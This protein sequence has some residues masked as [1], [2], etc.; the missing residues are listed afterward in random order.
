MTCSTKLDIS[1]AAEEQ[2]S[3]RSSSPLS[4]GYISPPDEGSLSRTSPSTSPSRSSS[5]IAICGFGLRL[6]GGVRDGDSFWDLLVNG[7]DARMP[8]PASR[9]N[10]LGFDAS[11]DSKDAIRTQHGYFLD[12]D[13]ASL[14]AS[15]FSMTKAELEKCDPQQRQLLEVTRECLDDAGE[16]DHRGQNVGCYVGNFGHDWME[17]SLREPQHTRSYN[18]LGYSDMML[19]NRVSYEFDLRGPSVVVKSACSASLVALHEACRALQAGDIAGAVVAGTSLILAPTLTSNFFAEGILSPS[20]SCKTFDAAAD[21][22]ARAEGIAAIYVKRL[23]D[24]IRDGN[25]VRA[26][27]RGTASNS[28]GRSMGIMSPSSE[29]HEALMRQVYAMAGLDPRQTAFVEC[30][31]TGTAAGDPIETRAVGNVFGERGVYITSVKPNVGHSEGCSGLTSLIKGILALEHQTIPPNIKFTTPNPKIPFAEKKLVVPVTPT[32]FPSDRAERVSI[33]SFGIGGSNAHAVIESLSQYLGRARNRPALPAAPATPKPELL[34]F[35]ANSQASLKRQIDAYRAYVPQRPEAVAE[36]AYTLAL[37]REHL[38]HRAFAIVKDAALVEVSG[39]SKAPIAGSSSSSSSS[40]PITMVF[41]G[42][43]AQWPEMGKQ[44]ILTNDRFRK[45]LAAM[46]QILQGFRIPPSWSIIE[47]LQK[48][49]DVSQVNCAELAQ[50]LCTALQ[51]ALYQELARGG[52]RPAAVVGHSSGE[53][54]AAYAAGRISLEYALAAAYYRGYVTRSGGRSGAMAAVGLSAADASRFLRPGVCV[55]C[56]NSPSSTTISGDREAL[57]VVVMTLKAEMPDVFARLLKVEMAYHS[58][59]M[60]PLGLDYLQLLQ[61]ENIHAANASRQRAPEALFISSVTCQVVTESGSFAPQYWVDNLTSPVRFNSAVASLLGLEATKDNLFLELGPH[62]TL[63]G[64]LRDICAAASKPCNYIATQVR[65]Q[66]GAANL[67]TAVGKLFQEAMPIDWKAFFPNIRKA[68]F[69]LPTYPWDHTSTYWYESRL[70]SAWRSRRFPHHCLLGARSVES[71]DFAPTW[72]NML[73]LEDVP[74]IA[75]HKVRQDVVFPLAGYISM[76]G[77]AI[78]QTAGADKGYRLRNVEARKALV[79]T[80]SKPVELVTVLYP[81]KSGGEGSTWYEFSIGSSHGDSWLMHCVGE[82]SAVEEPAAPSWIPGQQKLPRKLASPRFYEAMS[83]MG[84]VFGPEFRRL[85]DL[86]TSATD[87]VAEARVMA[88]EAD[89]P[90]LLHPTTI[91]ACIQLLIVADIKGLCRNLNQLQI[92]VVVENIEISRGSA[93]MVAQARDFSNG[94]ECLTSDSRVAVHMSGLQLAPLGVETTQT[95]IHA[96]ARLQWL[97]DFDFVDSTKLFGKPQR[98]QLEIKLE[99]QLTLLCVLESADM[100]AGVEPCHAHLGK[101][102]EW[103]ALQIGK[104]AAG[105][106]ELVDDDAEY[107]RLPREQRRKLIDETFARI[108][109]LPGKHSYSVG[110]KRVCDNA[111]RIFTGEVDTLELLLRD[112]V[113]QE[114]YDSVSFSYGDFVRLL[115]SNRP[116]LRILEVG[117]GTGGTTELTLRDALAQ[118]TLPPYSKYTFTDV[119]AGF[120]P[121]ARERFAYAPNMEFQTFDISQDGIAQGFQPASYDI[122]LAPNVVHATESLKVTLSNLEPLLKPDGFLLL[123]E[124]CSLIQSPNY[125]FGNF[126]GWWLGEAD[127]RKWEPYVQ[128]ERWDVDL[129]AAGFTGV[130]AAVADQDVPYRLAATIISRPSRSLDKARDGDRA[131][132][133]LCQDPGT[134]IAKRLESSLTKEGWAVKTCKLGEQVPDNRRPIISSLGLESC[135][136]DSDMTETSFAAFQELLRHL[137]SERILWLTR[138]FQVKCKD[139]RS[140]Q[141]LGVARTVR[142]ELS[143]PLFTLEIDAEEPRFEGLVQDVFDKIRASQ[144]EDDLHADRE[145]VVD[146][147]TICI[148]RYHPFDLTKEISETTAAS[149]SKEAITLDSEVTAGVSEESKALF[150]ELEMMGCTVHAVA[151]SVESVADVDKAVVASGK[152]IK[153]VFQLAMVLKDAPLLEMTFGEWT[154]AI[155]PKV[156]GTWN[157]HNALQGQQ[158][159]F[160]W[161]TSSILSAVDQPGQGNYLASGTFLEAF[162]QYRHSLG[163]PASVLN[164]CPVDG[165]GY[166][167][168]NPRARKNMKAQGIYLLGEREFLD[169]LELGLTNSTPISSGSSSSSSAAPGVDPVTNWMN[170]GQVLM[171]LR[172]EVDLADAGNRT[173]WRH[174]R[175][176]GMYHNIRAGGEDAGAGEKASASDSNALKAFLERVTDEGEGA[177]SLL[178][179][180]G[181]DFVAR[182]VGKKIHDLMLK[183]DEEVDIRLTL[184]QVG[185][186]SLMA[187]ELRRWIK[188]VSGLAMSVLEIMGSGSLRVLGAAVSAKQHLIGTSSAVL[189]TDLSKDL[190]VMV[191]ESSTQPVLDHIV[192]LVSHATL[193]AIPERLKDHLVVSPGGEHAGGL[194]SNKLILFPDGVY[195]EL[196]AFRDGIDPD[197]RGKHRWGRSTE[198]TVVD[199]AY[200]LAREEDFSAVQQRVRDAAAGVDYADPV[201]GGRTRPDGTVLRWSIGAARDA[202]GREIGPGSLPFW[203]LDR[204]PRDLRVPYENNPGA[205]GH[206]SGVRGVSRLRVSGLQEREEVDACG[207]VL[208]AIHQAASAERVWRFSVPAGSGTSAASAGERHTVSVCAAS[209]EDKARVRIRIVLTLSGTESSPSRIELVPGLVVDVE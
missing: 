161:L 189:L 71:P 150:E 83:R 53:I 137:S 175:R 61:D 77:E 101:Y 130:D 36:I 14:D 154:D 206:P 89:A 97:P 82:I 151:G 125:I 207:K 40:T 107:V 200:T 177:G 78:R 31:G 84:I 174:N 5:P 37:R 80:D 117:A 13:L 19:A 60:Q 121:Q 148:G 104:A 152:P 188:Q 75:D 138:P 168:E 27:V 163:L 142:T 153:G 183:P 76:A 66:D 156:D 127:G 54:A 143:L 196:I 38:P 9:Y 202:H 41:S 119:S 58:H 108:M 39:L 17:M 43:G 194:T 135:F 149:A 33:N 129:K 120:F 165:V 105:K 128:P 46:D 10:I 198:N 193:L 172:S 3:S 48:P 12:E 24:A 30:H 79:M 169:F 146:N 70:S 155:R 136:F 132:T 201:P 159:D 167:A 122:I 34:V 204:T 45:S 32:P 184:A 52:V 197:A 173:S 187:I 124:L 59:Q 16:R 62:S 162:C 164:I 91:D 68:V 88:A 6:P 57:E 98:S 28:D 4:S 81:R 64:P 199:W 50:P 85:D 65:N 176:M 49:A 186:D 112:D 23:D 51:I 116:N 208:D 147:G 69:G 123:T 111:D 26:V 158:L 181:I 144:D 93:D 192:V 22:F 114:L 178:S 100:V 42:Q 133:L 55:A 87:H 113:L 56:E 182:E 106:Y 63:A 15:F 21:G 131:V 141:T 44:L 94:V 2:A 185:L 115:A 139:P 190:P 205:T 67:L 20:A 157:L 1:A 72:R 195:I 145:F 126:V 7:R 103:L 90:F 170:R 102:R 29:A 18:V 110:I 11:L 74:W 179:G 180:E 96:A 171:G 92:P 25:P 73:N 109:E 203:C 166:V 99:E 134:G 160:F 191:A 35:S 140:A 209:G 86:K 8:I 47:E 95:D 118:N